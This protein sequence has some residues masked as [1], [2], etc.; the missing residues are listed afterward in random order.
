VSV[1]TTTPTA[2]AVAK[3]YAGEIAAVNS[4][5]LRTG[6]SPEIA[7]Q[8]TAEAIAQLA[9]RPDITR[10]I[11]YATTV[12]RG[13]AHRLAATQKAPADLAPDLMAIFAG[14]KPARRRRR[15]TQQSAPAPKATA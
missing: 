15:A 5:L 4:Y 11:A 13:E 7:A 10:G 6:F 9:S 14:Q 3:E 8:A 2:A 1:T 12:A